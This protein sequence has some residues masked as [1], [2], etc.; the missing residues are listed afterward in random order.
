MKR[1]ILLFL[2]FLFF[3][4]TMNVDDYIYKD[5]VW[6][7]IGRELMTIEEVESFIENNIK[8]KS[9]MELYNKIEY[10]ASPHEILTNKA[11]DC[12]DFVIIYLYLIYL[13]TGEKGVAIG[14][15]NNDINEN[16][17]MCKV[18]FH[19]YFISPQYIKLNYT[20]IYNCVVIKTIS[21]DNLMTKSTSNNTRSTNT[22]IYN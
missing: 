9:D 13:V 7:L 2:L 20:E 1:I 8:Y 14:V 4:C 5:Q 10:F 19:D 21:F 12:E 17:L 11:G 16:H 3:S 6:E 22:I 15:H 18:S